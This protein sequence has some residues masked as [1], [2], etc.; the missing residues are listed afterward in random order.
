MNALVQLIK[1][2][3]YRKAERFLRKML[4]ES[5]QDSYVLSQLANVLWNR[6]KDAEAL[7]YADKAKNISPTSPLVNYTRA[8]ILWSLE[9]YDQSIEEWDTILNMKESDVAKNGY[10]MRWAKSVM[11]DSR[12]YK[13]DCL[14]RLFRNKEALPL[15][16]KHLQ[17][18][19][20]G[21]ESDF[22]KKE[23]LL[24]YKVLKYGSSINR[25][26]ISNEGYASES[27]RKRI[28]KRI[29]VLEKGRDWNKL[30]RYLK[31]VC[32]HY[33]K[34]YYLQIILS[35]SCKKTDEKK[36]CLLYARMAFELEPNDPLVIYK[37]ADALRV[38]GYLENALQQFEELAAMG[39][40]YMAYSEHGEGM[41]WAKTL[42]RHTVKNAE[43]IRQQIKDPRQSL[44]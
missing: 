13:A 43:A 20:R 25:M 38:N 39:I 10:G 14:F 34:E 3:K 44:K 42:M 18:R 21:L 1:Q 27:Q 40:D 17:C 24:F 31:T 41:R 30:V 33:P 6:R 22:S 37:Y 15:M 4:G 23:A 7:L 8:R 32:R 11:N 12:Y 2:K 9:K 29:D 16:V 26:D 19:K 28:T 36:G 35:E 5:P